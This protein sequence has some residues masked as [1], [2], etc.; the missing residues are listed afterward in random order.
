MIQPEFIAL[1]QSFSAA[2]IRETLDIY[3][4]IVDNHRH[5]EEKFLKNLEQH[6]AYLNALH[7]QYTKVNNS[8]TAHVYKTWTRL[9]SSLPKQPR[10]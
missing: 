8:A 5:L 9:F 1:Y 3:E 7:R 4:P 10:Q 2:K 6:V